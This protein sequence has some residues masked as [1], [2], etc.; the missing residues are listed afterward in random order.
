VLALPTIPLISVIVA[1]E[2]IRLAVARIVESAGFAV[3][4]FVSS[5]EFLGSKRMAD[6]ACLII[7]AHLPGMGGL[8]LQTQL[9]S[10]SR[11]IPIVL[12]T[13]S[14]DGTARKRAL[15]VGA[16]D[17]LRK[18]SGEKALLKEIRSALRI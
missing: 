16:V 12:I 9:A 10:S 8:Q 6:T 11:Y 5:A 3:E 14:F 17:F 4:M 7:D 1:D 13:A 18:P 2:S 15:E